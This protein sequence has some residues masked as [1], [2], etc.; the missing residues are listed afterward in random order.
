MDALLFLALT[1]AAVAYS[2]H[3]VVARGAVMTLGYFAVVELPE[4]T[5]SALSFMVI[6]GSFTLICAMASANTWATHDGQLALIRRQEALAATDSLT[7]T[8]NRRAFLGRV[9]AAVD[10]AWGHPIVV[11]LVD[12]DG[13]KSAND[14]GVMRPATPCCRRLRAPSA[15]GFV[16][17]TPWPGSGVTS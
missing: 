17:P 15:A 6:M 11:C 10:A 5:S 2:P 4:V 14:A 7:G 3:G 13:F 8:P 1:Y 12:L 16:R 9:S